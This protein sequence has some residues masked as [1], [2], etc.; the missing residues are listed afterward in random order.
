M[1]LHNNHALDLLGRLVEDRPN[2]IAG[3]AEDCHGTFCIYCGRRG[4]K[5]RPREPTLRPDHHQD[6]PI[7]RGQQLLHN[8]YGDEHHGRWPAH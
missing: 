6:C 5:N 1:S 3:V 7:H 8:V 4:R 2:T